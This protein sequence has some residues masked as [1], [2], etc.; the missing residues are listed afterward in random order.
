MTADHVA[1]HQ[2]ASAPLLT[3]E[4]TAERLQVSTKS[5]RRWITAGELV[6]YRIGRQWRISEPDLQVFIKVR[7]A[8]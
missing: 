1:A 4:Q 8:G 6:A 2:P 7:R 5:V 3:I